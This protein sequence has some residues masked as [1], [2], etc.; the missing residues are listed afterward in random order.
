LDLAAG[1]NVVLPGH[2]HRLALEFIVPVAQNLNGPQ[3]EMD[4]SVTLGWQLAL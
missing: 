2:R 1:A 3:L 4:Y